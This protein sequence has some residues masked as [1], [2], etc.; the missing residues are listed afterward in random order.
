M[1]QHQVDPDEAKIGDMAPILR[2]DSHQTHQAAWAAGDNRIGR[3]GGQYA[4]HQHPQQQWPPA[5]QIHLNPMVLTR[6]VVDDGLRAPIHGMG[7]GP[8]RIAS[9]GRG[10]VL[11][12]ASLTGR[13]YSIKRCQGFVRCDMDID[14][15]VVGWV[16]GKNGE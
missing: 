1:R 5:S 11:G 3:S 6:D 14:A 7:I 12:D 2:M 8:G 9:M 4:S 13:G 15:E 10:D 16:I